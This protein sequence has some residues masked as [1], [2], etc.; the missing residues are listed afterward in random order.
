[1]T[2][3]MV[4]M[5]KRVEMIASGIGIDLPAK[6]MRTIDAV[7]HVHS[8]LEALIDD[9]RDRDLLEILVGVDHDQGLDQGGTTDARFHTANP[10]Y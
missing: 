4:E 2:L 6:K 1:M 3:F 5:M 9:D 10:R 8:P 7:V